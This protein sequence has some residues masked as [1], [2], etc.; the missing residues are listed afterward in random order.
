M[1]K[2]IFE[3]DAAFIDASIEAEGYET[4]LQHLKN[5]EKSPAVENMN[6]IFRTIRD[7]LVGSM[8]R[9]RNLGVQDMRDILRRLE[10]EG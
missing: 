6:G 10:M 8:I 3:L 9:S 1:A 4:L 7:L 5:V 2:A